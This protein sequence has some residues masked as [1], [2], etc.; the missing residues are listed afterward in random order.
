MDVEN[1]SGTFD[2]P[3]LNVRLIREFLS[4][5]REF[6][7][8]Y[9]YNPPSGAAPWGDNQSQGA[10]RAELARRMSD[11]EWA[12]GIKDKQIKAYLVAFYHQML[13]NIDL[14]IPETLKAA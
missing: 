7:L 8:S 4:A 13:D 12:V 10:M 14:Y 11:D 2:L 5:N 6:I 1:V 3:D 9:K